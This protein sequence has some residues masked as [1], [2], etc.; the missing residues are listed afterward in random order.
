ML[1]LRADGGCWWLATFFFFVF[2]VHM[3]VFGGG[4]TGLGRPGRVAPP[5]SRRLE[6]LPNAEM[7]PTT[8]FHCRL[9]TSPDGMQHLL[10]S[11]AV[12]MGDGIH[13]PPYT[14]T[15]FPSLHLDTVKSFADSAP[16]AQG[17]AHSALQTSS[18][19]LSGEV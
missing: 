2:V 16:V 7:L 1:A 5:P 12:D 15:C 10:W 8:R 6:A 4:S 13:W 11:V 17:A 19:R 18:D 9:L 3:K 14:G